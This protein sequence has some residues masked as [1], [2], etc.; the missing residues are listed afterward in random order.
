[1]NTI[2][3][4]LLT[5]TASDTWNFED[6]TV[7]ELPKGWTAAKTGA[8]LGSEWKVV[9]DGSKALAQTSSQGP[10]ALF[11][12]CI[13]DKTSYGDVDM[14]VSLKAVTGKL[15]QGG[16]LVW[17]LRDANNYYIARWNPLEDNFRVYKVVDGKRTQLATA[18]VKL[19]ADK[20]HMLRIRQVGNQIRCDLD[21]KQYLSATDDTFKDAGKIGLWSKAD[22]VTHFDDL[23]VGVPDTK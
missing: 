12:L 22:A 8:G 15:D 11:N 7:G 18:D 14:A 5:V 10:N 4:V 9:H 16:G 1:M 13:A 17:R 19:P 6:A 2:A 23:I 21:G 3:L 20:W